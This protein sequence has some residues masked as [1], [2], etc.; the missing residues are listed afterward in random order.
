MVATL[1]RA[2]GVTLGQVADHLGIHRNR[3]TDKISG[4]QHF[5]ESDI[6]AL[7]DYFG[8]APG[9]LFGD[10]VALLTGGSSSACTDRAAGH[11][12]LVAA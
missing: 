11:L 9:Q 8:V 3:L 12:R 7:A 5:R 6:L 1:A 10:P 2:K 4:R